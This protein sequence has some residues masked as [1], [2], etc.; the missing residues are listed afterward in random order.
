MF[1]VV[2]DIGTQILQELEYMEQVQKDAGSNTRLVGG[3]QQRMR[4][5]PIMME[6]R[7]LKVE[8]RGSP[9]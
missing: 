2:D 1:G 9:T 8:E 3:A 7:I 6:T 5:K 4:E